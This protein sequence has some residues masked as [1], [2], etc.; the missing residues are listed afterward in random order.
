MADVENGGLFPA[1]SVLGQYPFVLDRHVPTAEWGH[2]RFESQVFLQER[3]MLEHF[4]N[5]SGLGDDMRW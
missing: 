2:K 1:P 5:L 4:H 3:S